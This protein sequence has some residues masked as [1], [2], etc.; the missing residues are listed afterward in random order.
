MCKEAEEAVT[1]LAESCGLLHF[2]FLSGLRGE[3]LPSSSYG[4][5]LRSEQSVSTK[6]EQIMQE[7][8]GTIVGSMVERE[9]TGRLHTSISMSRYILGNS[10]NF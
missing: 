1:A 4:L 6:K 5:S 2:W 8:K 10:R 9:Q 3:W 7:E